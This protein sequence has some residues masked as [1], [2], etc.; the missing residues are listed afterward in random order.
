MNDPNMQSFSNTLKTEINSTF[1]Q[2][3]GAVKNKVEELKHF[4][5]K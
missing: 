3:N 4:N 5:Y 2:I 1:E